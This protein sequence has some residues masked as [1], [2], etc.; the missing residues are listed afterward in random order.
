M[1]VRTRRLRKKRRRQAKR[2]V[3]S[4]PVFTLMWYMAARVL[5]GLMNRAVATAIAKTPLGQ[6]VFA[7]ELK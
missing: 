2:L 5:A 3:R 7:S 6:R 1:K 4:G